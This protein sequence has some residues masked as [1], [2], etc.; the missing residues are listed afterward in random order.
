MK[1]LGPPRARGTG[2]RSPGVCRWLSKQ[3]VGDQGPA[4]GHQKTY[5]EIRGP[6]PPGALEGLVVG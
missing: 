1:E 3:V 5:A 6:R 4:R 2:S